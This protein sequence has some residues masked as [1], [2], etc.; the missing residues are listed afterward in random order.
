MAGPFVLAID[1]GTT[2]SRALIVDRHGQVAGGG[3]ESFPQHFP[4]PGWVEHHPADIWGS[5]ESAIATALASAGVRPRDLSAVGITNQ[6]E[7]VMAWD[8]A[9][10]E[11][12][13]PA[14]V[15]QD[16][17]TAEA[18]ERLKIAGHEA[19]LQRLTGLTVDPYFSGTKLAWILDSGEGLRARAER[20]EIAAGTIDTWLIWRLTGS[21]AHLSDYTNA[22]RTMLFNI[23][24][25]RWDDTLCDLLRVPRAVLPTLQPSRSA[26]GETHP[27]VLGASIPILG[28]AGDQQSAL[29]GQACIAPGL[30]KNTYGTGCF[31]LANAGPE[32]VH[33]EARLLCSLGAGSGPSGPEYV[34]EGSVFVA[35]AAVQWLRDEMHIVQRAGDIEALAASVP[36][37]GGVM[38]VPAFTGLG[39][40]YW[41]PHA[42]GAL[43]GL[44]RGTTTAHI[45]RATLEAIAL[46]SAELVSVI[47][48]GLSRP[49]VE[50]RVD[51][52]AAQNDL[53]MQMQ[54]DYAGIPVVRPVETETTALG[55]AYLAGI[56]AGIWADEHEIASL[57]KPERVFEPQMR[58]GQR[59]ERLALWRRAVER[60]QGWA[61]PS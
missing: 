11:P 9:T 58:P 1:Q 27:D 12:V 56:G 7:T 13:G 48:A 39:A 32:V 21:Q 50:L 42:R 49:L 45:A 35:G 53:L 30:A 51:G 61:G 3:Q 54:A 14:I 60:S 46:S 43:L 47:E 34:L 59:Q 28:V 26:F 19:N 23:L 18:C 22:S 25:G 5:T 36:D 8:R 24:K 52:G 4:R 55:A 15:W 31:L 16:R 17:R 38:F 41:D 20:G 6:R 40:P 57:W 29:F 2:S 44:T 33:S 10:G 37:T